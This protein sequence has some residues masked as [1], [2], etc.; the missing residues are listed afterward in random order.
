MGRIT[1]L[2]AHKMVASAGD[3]VDGRAALLSAGLDPDLPMDPKVMITD[4]A[5]YSMLEGMASQTD[6]TA[7][8]VT[9]GASMRCDEYGALG[10]AWKAAPDLLGFFFAC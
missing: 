8:P 3:A 10:L 4:E 7:L 2:F 1:S 6:V 5:Y 9:V